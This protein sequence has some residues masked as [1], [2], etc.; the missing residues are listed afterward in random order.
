VLINEKIIILKDDLKQSIQTKKLNE[1]KSGNITYIIFFIYISLKSKIKLEEL[2]KE[3][4]EKIILA[5]KINNEK[6]LMK[7]KINNLKS[8]V[9]SRPMS[10]S[11]GKL[12]EEE[13]EA[14]SS[15]LINLNKIYNRKNVIDE[16]NSDLD[17]QSIK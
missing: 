5:K 14:V 6:E 7:N 2:E 17:N 15:N 11:I 10:P 16:I 3:K 12:D 1:R 9:K 4:L 13:E 8:P